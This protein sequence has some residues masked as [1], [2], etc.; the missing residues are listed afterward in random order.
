MSDPI[1]PEPS[2]WVA[3]D[4]AFGPTAEAIGYLIRE[5]NSLQEWFRQLFAIM[6]ARLMQRFDDS[7]VVGGVFG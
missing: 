4:A 3:W 1:S 7:A 2:R 5:W 6:L